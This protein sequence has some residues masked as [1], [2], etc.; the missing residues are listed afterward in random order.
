MK[1]FSVHIRPGDKTAEHAV[2]IREGFSFWGFLLSGLWALS[3]RLWLAFIVLAIAFALSG[4]AS[5][6]LNGGPLMEVTLSL[7]VM[8]AFGFTA[9]D[10]R[11]KK[12]ERRGWTLM[13]VIAANDETDARYRLYSSDIMQIQNEI[14]EDLSNTASNRSPSYS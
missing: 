6:I 1:V 14:S 11:R 2:I 13:T 4:L 3:H 5:H 10:I 12:M 7:V 9:N 8:L